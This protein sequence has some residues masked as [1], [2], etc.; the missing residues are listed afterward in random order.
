MNSSQMNTVDLYT[1]GSI[2][3]RQ[4]PFIYTEWH[5]FT[6]MVKF[7]LAVSPPSFIA[8][9]VWG[10]AQGVATSCSL[11]AFQVSSDD[12]RLP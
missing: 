10:S 1:P 4:I 11:F 6:E 5:L 8:G 3:V 2:I 9:C 7:H 12:E